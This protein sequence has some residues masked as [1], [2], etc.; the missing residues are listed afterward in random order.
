MRFS[1]S[2]SDPM[3]PRLVD[4][5]RAFA[6]LTRLRILH[7]LSRQPLCVCHLQ[8]ALEIS[9]VQTSQHL[10]YLRKVGLVDVETVQAWRIYHVRKTPSVEFEKNLSTLQKCVKNQVPFERDLRRLQ[11]SLEPERLPDCLRQHIRVKRPLRLAT[12]VDASG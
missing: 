1:S 3:K 10:A 2:V 7:L 4:I 11:R 5:Y 12:A 9:Q 8:E 6:D